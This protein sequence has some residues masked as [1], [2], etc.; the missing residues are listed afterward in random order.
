M[1]HWAGEKQFPSVITIFS[2]PN[3]CDFYNNKAAV[4]KLMVHFLLMQNN[5]LDIQQYL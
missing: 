3:Y 1:Y 2:A 4:I 5:T